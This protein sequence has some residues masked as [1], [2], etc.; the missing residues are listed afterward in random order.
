MEETLPAPSSRPSRALPN[1]G[2]PPKKPKLRSTGQLAVE[3][4]RPE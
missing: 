1:G 4:R 3:T 2:A